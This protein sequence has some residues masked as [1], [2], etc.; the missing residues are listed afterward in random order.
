MN[1]HVGALENIIAG[2]GVCVLK[3]LKVSQVCNNKTNMWW[4][5]PEGLGRAGKEGAWL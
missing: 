5:T 3:F 4:D 1:T 2:D